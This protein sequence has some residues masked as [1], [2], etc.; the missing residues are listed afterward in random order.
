MPAAGVRPGPIARHKHH[1]YRTQDARQR[2]LKAKALAAAKAAPDHYL[3]LGAPSTA[4]AEDVKAAYR[5]AR[6][7][8]GGRM[9]CSCCRQ[10]VVHASRCSSCR[11]LHWHLRYAVPSGSRPTSWRM[12]CKRAGAALLV[13]Y[14]CAHAATPL[15]LLRSRAQAAGAEISPRP[16]CECC[17]QGRC[18]GALP[19]RQRRTQ[20]A[21]G[22]GAARSI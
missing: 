20:R 7:Q 15:L 6:R 17:A 19:P 18:R 14:W 13:C 2:L 12:P 11:Q 10:H 1:H 8:A 22:R 3:V 5:W 21:Q 4:S 9:Q 16:I